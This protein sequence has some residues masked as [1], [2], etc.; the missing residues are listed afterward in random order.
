MNSRRPHSR[1]RRRVSVRQMVLSSSDSVVLVSGVIENSTGGIEPL[2]RRRGFYRRYRTPA[3]G[4]KKGAIPHRNKRH[5][6][7][8]LL[9]FRTPLFG[10]LCK[11]NHAIYILSK[12]LWN[13][14]VGCFEVDVQEK[15]LLPFQ[16][17]RDAGII[18]EILG[19]QD[20]FGDIAHGFS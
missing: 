1:N 18:A 9:F 4:H 17:M 5:C 14:R 3:A 13:S 10:K 16:G 12:D 19:E 15:V 20:G 11:I 2:V 8:M 7:P 6:L